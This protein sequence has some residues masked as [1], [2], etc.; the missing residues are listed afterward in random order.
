MIEKICGKCGTQQKM[1]IVYHNK[2]KDEVSY[3]CSNC[4]DLIHPSACS[5]IPKKKIELTYNTY[6][7]TKE[8]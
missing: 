4:D 7:N 5:P 2:K 3:Y 6:V 8:E 1:K